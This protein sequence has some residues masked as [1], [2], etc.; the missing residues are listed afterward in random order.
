MIPVLIQIHD[1]PEKNAMLFMVS[2]TSIL[3]LDLFEIS[4]NP[5]MGSSP[6]TKA[7]ASIARIRTIRLLSFK[8]NLSIGDIGFASFPN[9][10]HTIHAQYFSQTEPVFRNFFILV[11][12]FS[13]GTQPN[14]QFQPMI[15]SLRFSNYQTPMGRPKHF[16]SYNFPGTNSGRSFQPSA[17]LT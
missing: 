14:R 5:G 4:I 10:E 15:S 6:A 11:F 17:A 16:Q 3:E 9:W 2:N 1:D 8:R 13:K 12:T 7:S